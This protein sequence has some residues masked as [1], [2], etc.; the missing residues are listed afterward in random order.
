MRS[1]FFPRAMLIVALACAIVDAIA[2]TREASQAPFLLGFR[3]MREL[4]HDV[5]HYTQGLAWHEG[6]LIE[7]AGR[8]GHS[9]LYEKDHA[10][11]RVAREVRL[12][13]NQFAEGATIFG[14][15]VVQL[16]WREGVAHVW[17]RL[18]RPLRKLRYAG[19]GWGITHDGRALITSDGSDALSFRDPA[20]FS[21]TRMLPV[22]A[23]GRPVV[24][25]NELEYARQRIF[26]NVWLS[27]RIVVIDPADGRVE[28]WLD[29][30]A[31][32]TRFD[33]PQGWQ[34]H[35]HVLNGIAYDADGDR[36]F[37]TGKCWPRLFEL[38]IEPLPQAR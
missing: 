30:A 31:L 23:A 1:K 14:D 11:G 27:D 12:P 9:A 24:R 25:L 3:V 16:T 36:F 20:D 32:K 35:E 17:D 7:S 37:V 22:H 4:P 34:A 28:A 38:K 2:A 26:A 8:Y 6:K 15:E 5:S 19:E 21:V 18:F 33:K 13:R 29:L 10:S